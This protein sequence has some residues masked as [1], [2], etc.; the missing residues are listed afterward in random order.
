M[1]AA[2]PEE[3]GLVM[4]L[5]TEVSAWLAMRRIVQWTSPPRPDVQPLMAREIAAGQVFLA[6]LAQGE[7]VLGVMRFEWSDADLWP[8]D[9]DG[10]GYVHSLAVRPAFHGRQAGGAMLRWAAEH[11]HTRGRRSLRLDCVAENGALR[12]YYESLGFCYLWNPRVSQTFSGQ[13]HSPAS[14]EKF[15]DSIEDSVSRPCI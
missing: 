3:L 15:G 10:G 6:R 9:P 5:L 4:E 11:V 2:R 13:P 1:S 7:E 8:E 12:R 14:A